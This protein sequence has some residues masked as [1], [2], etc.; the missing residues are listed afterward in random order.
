[1]RAEGVEKF[2]RMIGVTSHHRYRDWYDISCPFAATKH[3]GGR[4]DHPSSGISVDPV[5]RSVY[6]CHSCGWKGTLRRFALEWSI[7]CHGNP[8]PLFQLIEQEENTVSA[9]S[10]RLDEAWEKRWAPGAVVKKDPDWDVFNE[11]ELDQYKVIP[12]YILTRGF[13][14]A[15]CT[16]WGIGLDWDINRAVF[17]V[18]R[19]DGK[20]VGLVGRAIVEGVRP[21]YYNYWRFGKSFYLY[22]QHRLT[23]N[24][25]VIVVEGMLDVVR[26]WEY[27]LPVVGLM[28]SEIGD[29][30]VKLLLGYERVYLCL[31]DDPAGAKGTKECIRKMNNRVPL[32]R[33]NLPPGK[34]DP[35]QLLKEEALDAVANARLIY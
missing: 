5:H 15:T 12:Q 7:A 25:R 24:D 9:T 23:K 19:P 32:F 17:P 13:S 34:T 1:M 10:G 6:K 28:G 26:W 8:E 14:A 30:Q 11:Q 21:K 29:N 31:D 22:G 20:L 16:A 27:G 33:I 2:M 35:K 4:D 18:R 3:R